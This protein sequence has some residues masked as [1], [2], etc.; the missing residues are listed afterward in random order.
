MPKTNIL[1]LG[2]DDAFGH[3]SDTIMVLCSDPENIEKKHLEDV[4]F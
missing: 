1:L 4:E 3:R 2:V